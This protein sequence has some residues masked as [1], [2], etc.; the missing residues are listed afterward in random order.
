M[1]P[2]EQA[3]A[4]NWHDHKICIMEEVLGK[5]H[6]IVRHAL[7]PFSTGGALD[8]YYFP[9][10]RPGTAIATMEL[11]RV[12]KKGPSNAQYRTY[13]LVMFTRHPLAL[14]AADDQT[15]PFGRVHSKIVSVLNLVAPYCL[16]ARIS[17]GNTADA[18]MDAEEIGG[19][20]FIFDGMT[21]REGKGPAEFGLMAILEIFPSEM[22]FARE[23]GGR[24]LLDWL[25][26]TN[27]YPYSDMERK[28]IV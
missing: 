18:P 14:D 12:P 4:S 24:Q 17:P 8:L 7:L 6:N 21:K 19:K 20:C 11:T 9:N 23:F 27:H 13:E 5:Q 15:T 22:K 3:I 25:K 26:S 10:G 1:T 28:P 2:D 16:Q